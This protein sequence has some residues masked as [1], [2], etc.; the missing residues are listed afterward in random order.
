MRHFAH[1]VSTEERPGRRKARQSP[2]RR[3]V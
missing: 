1:L 2:A 3:P